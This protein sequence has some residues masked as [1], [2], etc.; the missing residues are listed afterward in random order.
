[1][2]AVNPQRSSSVRLE[3]CPSHPPLL[4]SALPSMAWSSQGTAAPP[5]ATPQTHAAYLLIRSSLL[6]PP[7]LPPR[8]TAVPAACLRGISGRLLLAGLPGVSLQLHPPWRR[9]LEG[10]R[11]DGPPDCPVLAHRRRRDWSHA[12]PLLFHRHSEERAGSL[13]TCTCQMGRQPQA[14]IPRHS[15]R[16]RSTTTSNN[17]N[18]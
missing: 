14:V 3:T 12:R 2:W 18:R 10:H 9:A 4:A 8:A 13:L 11:E 6:V 7:L 15:L 16:L 1:M 17:S 5:S